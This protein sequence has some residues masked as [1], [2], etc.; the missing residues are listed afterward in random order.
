MAKCTACL[1]EMGFA[2]KV[3]AKSFDGLCRS[4]TDHGRKIAAGLEDKTIENI[5]KILDRVSSAMKR[6]GNNRLSKQIERIKLN[7]DDPK[8]KGATKHRIQKLNSTLK[9]IAQKLKR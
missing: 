8:F 6:G 7:I 1:K 5:V 4:C 3:N 9:E 2:D